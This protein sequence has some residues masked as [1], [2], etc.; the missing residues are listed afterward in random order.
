MHPGAVGH[1]AGAPGGLLALGFGHGFEFFLGPTG[2]FLAGQGPANGAV[3]QGGDAVGQ[4]R[5]HQGLGANDA[6][7]ATRAVDH[8][9]GVGVRRQG[10][11][12]QHQLGPWHADAA[13][14]AHGL[15]LVKPARIQHHQIGFL[16]D[17]GFDF[18]GRQGRRVALML[19]QLAKGFAGHVH[20]FEDLAPIGNPALQSAFQQADLGVT[21]GLQALRRNR[22]QAFAVVHHHH[23]G[24]QAGNAGPGIGFQAAQA[25]LRGKQGVA[26]GKRVFFPDIEQGNFLVLAEGLVDLGKSGHGSLFRSSLERSHRLGSWVLL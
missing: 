26:L 13:R 9:V 18:G 14:D 15:V 22:R 5:I 21:Q 10:G 24:V 7:G 3:A 2:Q 11:G 6:A 20:V 17:Q 19:D 16:L 25:H 1:R 12:A 4:A 8:D 23:G